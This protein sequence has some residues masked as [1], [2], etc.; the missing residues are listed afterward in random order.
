MRYQLHGIKGF[1]HDGHAQTRV[2]SAEINRSALGLNRFGQ[3]D[4]PSSY[5]VGSLA[6]CHPIPGGPGKYLNT[7]SIYLN[8]RRVQ[9]ITAIA[10]DTSHVHRCP[11]CL[12][13]WFGRFERL[14]RRHL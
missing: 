14:H 7:V 12:R 3:K 5:Y 2:L 10:A 6:G 8:Q 1:R 9:L 4:T 13:P 11:P